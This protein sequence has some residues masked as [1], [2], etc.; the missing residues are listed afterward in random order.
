M[1]KPA[2]GSKPG[3]CGGFRASAAES[4]RPL[5]LADF[6]LVQVAPVSDRNLF[7]G[8][9]PDARAP[10]TRDRMTDQFEHPAHLTLPPFV[11]HDLHERL[12]VA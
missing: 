5:Q 4:R 12:L 9:R 7:I 8:N 1:N 3:L 6:F 11:Q 10:E 2:P